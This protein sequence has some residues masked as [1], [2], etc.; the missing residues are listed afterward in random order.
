MGK[1]V[2]TSNILFTRAML[3][4]NIVWCKIKL[5]IYSNI[6][7]I[8]IQIYLIFLISLF[9]KY[10]AIFIIEYLLRMNYILYKELD[11]VVH[12]FETFLDWWTI[13]LWKYQNIFVILT[14][15]NLNM[16]LPRIMKKCNYTLHLPEYSFFPR[17][18]KNIIK[19]Y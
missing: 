7:N 1:K 12:W 5:N 9:W 10:I 14:Q 18:I 13:G 11:F 6:Y 8:Y 3:Y 4:T 15:N 19:M 17:E 16:L 2:I